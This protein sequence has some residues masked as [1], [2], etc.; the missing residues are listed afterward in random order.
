MIV[1]DTYRK[2]RRR[3][4]KKARQTC[5]RV[6]MLERGEKISFIRRSVEMEESMREHKE[7]M[8]ALLRGQK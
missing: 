1:T 7:R 5:P 6:M 2:A 3:Q 4:Q 8:L